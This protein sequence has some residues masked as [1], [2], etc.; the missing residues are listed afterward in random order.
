M[1]V[2]IAYTFWVLPVNVDTIQA[3]VV[4]KLRYGIGESLSTASS[5]CVSNDVLGS[6]VIRIPIPAKR[7]DAFH[8]LQVL[9]VCPLLILVDDYW[10]Q[11]CSVNIQE[12][13]VDV[14]VAT[15]GVCVFGLACETGTVQIPRLVVSDTLKCRRRIA[16]LLDLAAAIRNASRFETRQ[17]RTW[18][19]AFIIFRS[20]K[21]RPFVLT[22]ILRLTGRS[23]NFTKLR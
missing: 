13:P 19:S 23:M 6:T 5:Q 17:L 20:A 8:V 7:Y 21:T 1:F 12:G 15:V 4:E 9:E 2:C 3:L 16:I 10:L 22:M 18:S 14:C 11:S